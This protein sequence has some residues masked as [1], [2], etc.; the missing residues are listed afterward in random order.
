MKVQLLEEKNR[1]KEIKINQL[2]ELIEKNDLF[3]KNPNFDSVVSKV[4]FKNIALKQSLKKGS[5]NY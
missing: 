1:E 2:A 3:E 5:N 4:S